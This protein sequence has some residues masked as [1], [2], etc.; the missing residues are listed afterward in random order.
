MPE[1]NTVKAARS[2]VERALNGWSDGSQI[3]DLVDPYSIGGGGEGWAFVAERLHL[4]ATF[5]SP[6]T[7]YVVIKFPVVTREESAPRVDARQVQ[8]LR[9]EYDRRQWLG[10][11]PHLGHLP[12]L[13]YL[14]RRR[15]EDQQ[16]SFRHIEIETGE[17]AIPVLVT[18]L[19]GTRTGGTVPAD[20]ASLIPEEGCWS[21]REILNWTVVARGLARALW[22]MHGR[23]WAHN[24][25]KPENVVLYE[26]R[27][28][29]HEVNLIDFGMVEPDMPGSIY[30]TE[31][32]SFRYWRVDRLRP[33]ATRAMPREDDAPTLEL[34]DRLAHL[35]PSTEDLY[36]LGVLLVEVLL[37]RNKTTELW[38]KATNDLPPGVEPKDIPRLAAPVYADLIS[39]AVRE[40][41]QDDEA[42]NLRNAVTGGADVAQP[43]SESSPRSVAFLMCQAYLMKN[44]AA[45]G[46]RASERPTLGVLREFLTNVDTRLV[47]LGDPQTTATRL[48]V[49]IGASP[50]ASVLKFQRKRYYTPIPDGHRLLQEPTV[51][52]ELCSEMVRE[53]YVRFG[54]GR[55][56]QLLSE[57]SKRSIEGEEYNIAWALRLLT[58]VLLPRDRRYREAWQILDEWR[59]N[60]DMFSTQPRLPGKAS[61]REVLAWWIERLQWRL[62]RADQRERRRGYVAFPG[63]PLENAQPPSE[64]RLRP[65]TPFDDPAHYQQALAWSDDDVLTKSMLEKAALADRTAILK[66]A[67]DY[68]Q[69]G[70]STQ[71]AVHA[72]LQIVRWKLTQI[73]PDAH[74]LFLEMLRTWT[75]AVGW[76]LVA[77]LHHEYASAMLLVANQTR[78]IFPVPKHADNKANKKGGAQPKLDRAIPNPDAKTPP[79]VPDRKRGTPTHVAPAIAATPSPEAVDPE[80]SGG[81]AEPSPSDRGVQ[82]GPSKVSTSMVHL[83]EQLIERVLRGVYNIDREAVL[84]TAA[85]C[86]FAAASTYTDIDAPLL[87]WRALLAAG[88]CLSACQAPEQ[89]LDAVRWLQFAKND[90]L[91]HALPTSPRPIDASV[92]QPID[93]SVAQQKTLTDVLE[94]SDHAIEEAITRWF[95]RAKTVYKSTAGTDPGAFLSKAMFGRY[96]AG[97]AALTA[98]SLGVELVWESGRPRAGEVI[99]RMLD[100]QRGVLKGS[101]LKFLELEC[102]LGH[103]CNAVAG[104]FPLFKE[105]WGVESM[106]WCERNARAA[107]AGSNRVRIESMDIYGTDDDWD[108]HVLRLKEKVG[109]K[110][111]NVVWMHDVLVRVS[112][113]KKVLE[114]A[115]KLLEPD[116]LLLMTDWL[117]SKQMSQEEWRDLCEVSWCTG[118][119]TYPGYKRLLSLAQFERI[120]IRSQSEEMVKALEWATKTPREQLASLDSIAKADFSSALRAEQSFAT[121]LRLAKAGKLGWAWISARKPL[122]TSSAPSDQVRPT[123]TLADPVRR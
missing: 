32:G 26:S 60:L 109:S 51:T 48:L 70:K 57:M 105:V 68:Q 86:A 19:Q 14:P 29:W 98:G 9:A 71:E 104:S 28:T 110:L 5:G 2:V 54:I 97:I 62:W 87:A 4:D 65:Q 10:D 40:G 17:D 78:R 49:N 74:K 67:E 121:L 37:G 114:R 81:A 116:G 8:R 47:S 111:F 64:E 117:H 90:Y 96:G 42:A 11:A 92:T 16:R 31:G 77:D 123:A 119:E 24:D 107:C 50:S 20:L 95:G 15:V 80:P 61:P 1:D 18:A 25:I 38:N 23:G 13:R 7:S 122:L 55:L 3:G 66:R 103:D 56:K 76:S 89:C 46:S 106:P 72:A 59:G 58:G 120:E 43:P 99:T 44:P 39:A 36:A 94:R 102:G 35:R 73:G 33:A 21:S 75:L 6:C 93:A 82:A 91:L 83:Q 63:Q 88:E 84:S 27:G 53:G 12:S 69:S 115:W 79:Q 34:V 118:P 113:R 108:K 85:E 22:S 41:I 101:G 30:G 52:I 100:S 45:N 112:N